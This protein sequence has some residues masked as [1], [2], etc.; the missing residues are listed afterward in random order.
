MRHF[1]SGYISGKQLVLLD[2]IPAR[3]FSIVPIDTQ[4]FVDIIIDN[5]VKFYHLNLQDG[6]SI[7]NIS[8][9]RISFYN[10]E[11]LIDKRIDFIYDDF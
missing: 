10:H 1:D 6:F 11:S 3:N 2:N 9:L 8:Y 7:N 5:D 4:C